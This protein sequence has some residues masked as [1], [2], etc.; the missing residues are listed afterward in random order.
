M[1]ESPKM[2]F[3]ALVLPYDPIVNY[4]HSKTGQTYLQENVMNFLDCLL[5]A[6]RGSP[7]HGRAVELI[8]IQQILQFS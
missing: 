6:R 8:T 3:A 4:L 2:R 5:V 1:Y 7:I